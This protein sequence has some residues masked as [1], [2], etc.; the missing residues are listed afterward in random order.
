MHLGGM[1]VRQIIVVGKVVGTCDQD[2]LCL[3]HGLLDNLEW[4]SRHGS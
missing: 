1:W 4:Q 2:A 3:G